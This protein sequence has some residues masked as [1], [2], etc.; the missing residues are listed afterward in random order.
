MG[1]LRKFKQFMELSPVSM[2]NYAVKFC[3]QVWLVKLDVNLAKIS[4]AIDRVLSERGSKVLHA[5][6]EADCK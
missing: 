4:K 5:R 1:R 6:M 3:A 2:R